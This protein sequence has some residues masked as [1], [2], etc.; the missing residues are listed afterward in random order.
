MV[1]LGDVGQLET[2][3]VLFEDSVN[4][5]ARQVQVLQEWKSFWAQPMEL[6]G[7]VGQM[8]A[9]FGSFG[10]S[11]NL[12]AIQVH[13]LRQTYHRLEIILDTPDGTPR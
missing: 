10:Y 6:L 12:G 5:D 13:G 11:V 9:C 2:H 4:L 1:L 7:Y 8:E 3:F